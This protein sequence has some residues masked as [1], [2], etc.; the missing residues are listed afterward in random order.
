MFM[1]CCLSFEDLNLTIV[2][3]PFCIL[4]SIQ[5]QKIASL[6]IPLV[7]EQHCNK[8]MNL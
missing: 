5:R 6:F 1:N 8:K 4:F 2:L 7:N 3:L